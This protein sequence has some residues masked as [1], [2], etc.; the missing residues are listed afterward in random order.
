MTTTA[1]IDPAKLEEFVGRFTN[2]LGAVM[3]AATIL[4]GDELGIYKAMADGEPL[5]AHELA[6]RTGIDA[7]YLEEWLSAQAA[8]G[9]AEYDAESDRFWLSPEQ[10]FALTNEDNPLFI[11]GGIEVA[12]STIRDVD[13]L[14]EAIRTGRACPG[15]S[16]T[17]RSSTAR[18]GSSNPTTAATSSTPGCPRSTA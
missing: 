12:A 3:H 5:T 4:I 14:T 6:R 16:T 9:Y 17:T 11:P 10:A 2:D 18:T 7:R 15:A 8:S 13:L 1:D